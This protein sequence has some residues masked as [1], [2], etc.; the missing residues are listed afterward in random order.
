[1]SV[2]A[3]A[4]LLVL[5]AGVALP[6]PYRRAARCPILGI[7]RLADHLAFLAKGLLGTWHRPPWPPS[8]R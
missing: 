5:A 7:L 4:V 3:A 2:V 1:V 6:F 8:S